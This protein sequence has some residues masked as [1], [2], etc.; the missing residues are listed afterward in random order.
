MA[1][2]PPGQRPDTQ[3]VL[4]QEEAMAQALLELMDIQGDKAKSLT[5]LNDE[6]VG[7]LTLLQ[8]MHD[9]IK[10]KEIGNFVDLY[11]KFKVSRSRLGRREIINA[12]S[13]GGVQMDDKRRRGSIKDLFAGMR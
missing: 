13:F 9:T 1:A 4:G 2:S 7:V 10:I 12:I 11:C 8:T 5:D 3:R 6:E